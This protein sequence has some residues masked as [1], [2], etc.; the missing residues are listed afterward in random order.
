ML[1]S[2]ATQKLPWSLCSRGAF[3][4]YHQNQQHEGV[5]PRSGSDRALLES[6]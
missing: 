5:A 1:Q 6:A 4:I 3:F 2:I